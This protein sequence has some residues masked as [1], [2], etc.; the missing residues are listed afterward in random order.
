M[1]VNTGHENNK[2]YQTKADSGGRAD[3]GVCL[4]PLIEGVEV[5]KPAQGMEVLPLC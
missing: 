3:Q 4:R 2:L 5:T 1:D